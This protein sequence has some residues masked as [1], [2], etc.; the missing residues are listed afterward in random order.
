MRTTKQK[1][2]QII[3]EELLNVL[4]EAEQMR[5]TSPAEEISGALSQIMRQAADFKEHL[6]RAEDL[7]DVPR[8]TELDYNKISELLGS[9]NLFMQSATRIAS[10]EYN[11]VGGLII[12]GTGPD[13]EPQL[14]VSRSMASQMKGEKSAFTNAQRAAQRAR[15]M[16]LTGGKGL[17]GAGGVTL[18]P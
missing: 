16:G 7:E 18:D 2:Q 17:P 13:G 8:G 9:V 4:A 10:E 15:L 6:G 3:K 1:L 14:S 12:A 11:L 5:P